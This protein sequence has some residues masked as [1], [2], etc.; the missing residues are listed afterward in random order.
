MQIVM[1][2]FVEEVVEDLE[3]DM[4]LLLDRQ[5]LEVVEV[6]VPIILE[7]QVVLL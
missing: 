4:E 1:I 2:V 6:E 7:D 5:T 3:V